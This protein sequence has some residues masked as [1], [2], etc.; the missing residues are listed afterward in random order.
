MPGKTALEISYMGSQT[1]DLTNPLMGAMNSQIPLGTYM[2][3]D[4]NPASKYYGKVLALSNSTTGD[5][6]ATVSNNLQDYV[7]FTHYSTL[8]VITHVNGAWAN[9][10]SLQAA[11]FKRQGSLTYNLNYTWSKTLGNN[12]SSA[13]PFNLAN[14][15]GVLSQDRSHVLN[16]TYAYEVGNRFK[17]RLVGGAL[18]GWML[19][20]IT[21]VQSGPD[22]PESFSMNMGFGGTD[23]LTNPTVTVGSTPTTITRNSISN[24]DFLG[25]PSYTL[26]PKL[27][28]NPGKG[29]KQGQYINSSC[30]AI[31]T[32]PTIDPNTGVLTA[33][34]GNGQSQMPYFHGPIYFDSDLSA[35]RTIRITEHQNAQIK[36]SATNFVN[37]ALTSFDQNNPNNLNLSL[38]NGVLTTTGG[39]LPNGGQW[40]YGVPNEKFGRRV[41]EMSL[42]YNF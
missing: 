1:S 24:T 7:P 16:A 39:G 34:G 19:S 32:L 3:P 21:G 6:N 28:C 15:Y 5:S 2:K 25:T 35:S 4:P 17:T 26:F 11:L 22:F 9:Y 41:L 27:T 12:T 37:H 14:D 20:G 30:F 18:N 31:P 10:N 13:D 42:R 36:F 8:G 29:L 40:S 33:L 23:T 38:S